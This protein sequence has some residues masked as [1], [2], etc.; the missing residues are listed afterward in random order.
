[1]PHV[2]LD[3][4]AGLALDLD[5]IDDAVRRHV[6][7]CADC[8]AVLASLTEARALAGEGPLVPPPDHVRDRVM[9]H[10]HRSDEDRQQGAVEGGVAQPIPL[11]VSGDARRPSRRRVPAWAAGLA[12]G[13]ALVAGLGIGRLTVGDPERPE[14]IDPTPSATPSATVVAAAALTALDSDAPRGEASAV[15]SDDTVTLR[16]RASE[17]GDEDGFHEVWLINVDG[18]RMVALGV[19]TP[20]DIGEFDVPQGVIDEGYRIVD[21]SVEP[22]DGDPT[23]SGV[24]L[25]RGELT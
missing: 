2:D 16:V 17:L 24:S 6:E 5:D 8:S 11:P 22:D 7:S 18:T 19:L 15:R 13:V 10:V 25:A 14:A 21:I 23:H 12:A 9:A 3:E 1:M 20:G 4:I